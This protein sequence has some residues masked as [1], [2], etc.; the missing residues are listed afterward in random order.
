MNTI[1][2]TILSLF[3]ITLLENF[4]QTNPEFNPPSSYD[5]R[6]VGIN[7]FI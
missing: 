5:L 4:A 1:L 6:N 7:K 3:L 2:T